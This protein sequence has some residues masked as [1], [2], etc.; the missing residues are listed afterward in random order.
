MNRFNSASFPLGPDS[1]STAGG[2]DNSPSLNVDRHMVHRRTVGRSGNDDACLL[3]LHLHI[4]EGDGQRFRV[5]SGRLEHQVVVQYTVRKGVAGGGVRHDLHDIVQR[6][7]VIELARRRGVAAA[8]PL[9]LR[10]VGERLTVRQGLVATGDGINISDFG[11]GGQAALKLT[12]EDRHGALCLV[13]ARTQRTLR[14]CY[15]EHA[16]Q[17]DATQQLQPRTT[18]G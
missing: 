17:T 1:E 4:V 14:V 8:A 15:L 9:R 16:A 2:F 7:F 10:T 3:T 13:G 5:H 6:R 12:A 11:P 18:G